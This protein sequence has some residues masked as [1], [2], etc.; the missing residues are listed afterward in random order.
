MVVKQSPKAFTMRWFN[1]L[2]YSSP[3]I[4]APFLLAAAIGLLYAVPKIVADL[5]EP[6]HA[7]TSWEAFTYVAGLWLILQVSLMLS[8]GILI[9]QLMEP[10]WGEIHFEGEHFNEYPCF[11]FM[12][13]MCMHVCAYPAAIVLFAVRPDLAAG[14]K[15]SIHM[16]V[17]L[18]GIMARDFVFLNLD[19]LYLAHHVGA[20]AVPVLT[21]GLLQ[22]G[23]EYD[24]YFCKCALSLAWFMVGS[25]GVDASKLFHD[26]PGSHLV[27]YSLMTLS[28]VMASYYGIA[29][30][31]AVNSEF[32]PIWGITVLCLVMMYFRQK[33]AHQEAFAAASANMCGKH[34]SAP[35]FLSTIKRRIKNRNPYAGL[36]FV[37]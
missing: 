7:D 32:K 15:L 21:W 12:P 30:L 11:T 28:H 8:F 36:A 33:V 19:A 3:L 4:Q 25:A 9:T 22:K 13:S 29:T 20:I 18:V 14:T 27:Y 1:W 31:I 10:R 5:P 17:G 23:P 2:V 34:E 37:L 24:V 6:L 16:V 26:T 35:Q